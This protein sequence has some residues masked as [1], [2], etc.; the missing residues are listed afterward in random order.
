MSAECPTCGRK[1]LPFGDECEYCQ[2][3][4]ANDILKGENALLR[5]GIERLAGQIAEALEQVRGWRDELEYILQEYVI[6]GEIA[7]NAAADLGEL[8]SR[9]VLRW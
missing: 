1:L 4:E 9:M 6:Q 3:R 7:V 8:A 5:A 2:L